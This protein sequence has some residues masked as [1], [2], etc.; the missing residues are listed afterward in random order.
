MAIS[1][2]EDKYRLL[3][4]DMERIARYMKLIMANQ[5]HDPMYKKAIEHALQEFEAIIRRNK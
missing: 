3:M 4:G 1:K 2:G 5:A